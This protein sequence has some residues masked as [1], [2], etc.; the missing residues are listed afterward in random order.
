MSQ[1]K[2]TSWTNPASA[3]ARNTSVGFEV[4]RVM[5][6]DQTN[7]GSWMWVYGMTS[8]Y[9]LDVDA[10]TITTSNGW[11]PV[12]QSA[13]FG[14]PI[15]GVSNAA[16]VVF[17]CSFL[18]QFSFAVGDTVKATEIAD[19]LTGTGTLNGTYTVITVSATQITCSESTVGKAA[20]VSGGFLS[21][22]KNSSNVPYPTVNVAIEGGTIGTGMVGANN[23]YMVAIFEGQNPVV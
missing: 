8:G 17:T 9:Y 7:G 22:V 18:D 20:W 16:D 21:Q 3:V 4:T 1:L 10:G 12:S 19:D 5:T 15:T 2:T 14:A 13:L 11:T 6:I 23:A